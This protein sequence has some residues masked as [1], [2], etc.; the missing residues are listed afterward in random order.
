[1]VDQWSQNVDHGYVNGVAF[2]DMRKAF[3]AVNHT[4][5]LLKLKFVGCTNRSLRWFT[6][7]LTGRSQFVSIKGKKSSTRAVHYGVTSGF[8]VSAI[9][10]LSIY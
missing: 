10:F 4:V 1:M 7:Y 3:D 2:I 9:T 8:S 6:S 5:L